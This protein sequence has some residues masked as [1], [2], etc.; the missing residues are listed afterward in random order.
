[1]GAGDDSPCPPR[2]MHAGVFRC[3]GEGLG[4]PLP[5]DRLV[6]SRPGEAREVE[7]GRD[8][9]GAQRQRP[10]YKRRRPARAATLT[11]PPRPGRLTARVCCGNVTTGR[12]D[13]QQL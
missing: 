11:V 5:R 7:R 2:V 4:E 3:A 10:A 8:V 13:N 12:V 1:M 9:V 6:P